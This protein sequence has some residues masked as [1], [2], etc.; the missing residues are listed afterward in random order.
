MKD[1]LGLDFLDRTLRTAGIV[2]LIFLP[3][4]FYYLGSYRTLAILS[5]GVWG[6][7]NFV[8]LSAVVRS[9]IRPEGV[10]RRRLLWSAVIKF[11]LLYG[12]GYA[13]LE[14]PVFTPGYLLIGFSVIMA[15]MLL[16]ALARVLLKM[17]DRAGNGN[18][19][20]EAR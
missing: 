5:G 6:I 10:D 7:I 1:N 17:D 18:N 16:K 19:L 12:A 3:F 14:V 4:G 15:L 11:P 9:V 13:L 2:L 8:F 20:Q